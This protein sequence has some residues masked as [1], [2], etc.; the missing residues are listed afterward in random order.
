MKR[1]SG[2]YLILM[3]LIGFIPDYSNPID[4]KGFHWFLWGSLNTLYLAIITINHKKFILP[5]NPVILL[6]FISTNILLSVG[7]CVN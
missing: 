4:Y 7:I 3:I 2:L 1:L 6:L 5:N